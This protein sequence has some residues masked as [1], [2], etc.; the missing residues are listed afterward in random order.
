VSASLSVR[1]VSLEY[2]QPAGTRLPVLGSVTATISSGEFVSLVGPSGCGKSTL[3]RILAGLKMPTHGSVTMDA[4]PIVE[5]SPRIAIM[6]QDANL[7]PWRTVVQN[8]A[9]PL[10]I[11]GHPRDERD[12][13]AKAL[14]PRL[15][16]AEFGDAFPRELS[17]GMAQR[18]ALGRVLV[19]QPDVL[20]LDEPFGALDALTRERISLDLLNLWQ[21]AKPTILMVTH[22]IHEAVLLSDRVLVMSRRPGRTIADVK[23]DLPRPRAMTDTYDERFVAVARQVRFAIEGA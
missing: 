16:L 11:A 23:V 20:L 10:E 17:G 19:Q 18:A 2:A 14:L 3:L 9:L 22:D 4:Q 15:G 21:V 8:I 1:N 12:A 13:R 5:P 6:F 7:M